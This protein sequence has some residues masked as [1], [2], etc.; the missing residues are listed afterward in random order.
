MYK[1]HIKQNVNMA[2][3]KLRIMYAVFYEVV[4]GQKDHH[5]PSS[6]VHEFDIGQT[7]WA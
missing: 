2:S 4:T 1:V 6:N 3:Q 5:D 7:L